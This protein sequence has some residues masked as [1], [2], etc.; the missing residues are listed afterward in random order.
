VTPEQLIR[1]MCACSSAHTSAIGKGTRT[2]PK[3]GWRVR[4]T[5]GAEGT[6]LLLVGQVGA[7]RGVPAT[8]DT[9]AAT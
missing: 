6:A 5:P 4:P 8:S 3:L 1:R 2:I 7:R 9:P